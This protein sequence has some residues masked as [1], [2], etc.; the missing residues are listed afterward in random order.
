MSEAEYL[1]LPEEKPYLEYVDGVVVQKVMG[2]WA[3]S[4]LVT[5]FAG[6]LDRF[7]EAHGGS[8]PTDLR[9]LLP[10]QRNYRLADISYFAPRTPIGDDALPTIAVE[11]RSPDETVASQQRKCVEWIEAGVHEAWLVEPRTRTVEVFEADGKR[12]TLAESDRLVSAGVTGLE[13][14][15]AALFK[16]LDR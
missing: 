5:K 6:V 3:H 8:A 4:M 10:R 1:A 7:S 12:R 16:V 13:V 2:D 15:L 14:D 9:S 11:V